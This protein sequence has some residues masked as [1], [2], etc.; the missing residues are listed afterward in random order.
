MCRVRVKG[1]G[2]RVAVYEVVGL[3]ARR[4]L[5][6]CLGWYGDP[7]G[8]G[9]SYE[10]GNPVGCGVQGKCLGSRVRV[11]GEGLGLR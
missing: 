10:R 5:T 9:V 1:V 2:F 7:R 8:V 4:M 3:T 6:T 11:K